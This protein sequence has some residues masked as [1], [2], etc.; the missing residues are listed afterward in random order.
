MKK[1]PHYTSQGFPQQGTLASI[2]W[3]EFKSS[4]IAFWVLPTGSIEQH[5]PH[6]PLGADYMVAQRLARE[7]VSLFPTL[8]LPFMPLGVNFTFQNWPGNIG[9]TTGTYTRLLVEVASQASQWCPRLLII[10]GHDENQPALITAAQELVA[11]YGM[12]VVIFEWAELILDVLRSVC[13]SKNEMHAGEGLTSLFLYW[14][15]D[16]VRAEVITQ[17]AQSPGGLASDDIHLDH[18]AIFPRLLNPNVNCSNGVFGNP[19]LASTEKGEKIAQA[20][21]E[22]VME[23][24]HELQWEGV[25]QQ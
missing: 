23:L 24:V 10:N 12:Q 19:T 11:T 22:R 5:G 25:V 17:G 4:D 21:I 1:K 8:Q 9:L 14:F 13:E 16:D 18:R 7:V 20:L 15:P 2:T 6:L 3:T